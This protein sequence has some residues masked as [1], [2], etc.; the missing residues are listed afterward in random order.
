MLAYHL[1]TIFGGFDF[2]RYGYLAV[3][4]FFVLSG[5]VMA[6]TYEPRFSAGLGPAQ[7]L[8]AR[9][10]RLAP[11]MAVG[12]VLG[13]ALALVLG[14]GIEIAPIFAA[15]LA[16]VP[17]PGLR[18]FILNRPTW[19]I[20]F[21]V[22]ANLVHAAMLWRVRAR[23]L[24]TLV[25][26]CILALVPFWLAGDFNTG[27]RWQN[28]AG[29]FPRVIATYCLGILAFRANVPLPHLPVPLVPVAGYLGALSFPL[30]ATHYPVLLSA[31]VF[32]LGPLAGIA[33]SLAIAAGMV[34]A[35]PI[36]WRSVG[37]RRASA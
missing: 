10:H 12:A 3:D 24:V 17:Q 37:F 5:Y 27:S 11:T 21:E 26:T 4:I 16:L 35:P 7:F 36:R 2:I 32:D 23:F 31:K 33:C 18:P 25:A 20:F 6:R 29:G 19:S 30:Y 13:C 8:A 15:T 9:Y 14:A 1:H 34:A 28:F 22:F